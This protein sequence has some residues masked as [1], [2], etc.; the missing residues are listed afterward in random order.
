MNGPDLQGI[1]GRNLRN[2]RRQQRLT[3]GDLA[4]RA[5]I[6]TG[7]I[8]DIETSKRWP[9][10]DT[11]C[12]L[13]GALGIA[14]FQLLLPTEDSPWFDRRRVLSSYNRRLIE[15]IDRSCSQ[16]FEEMIR[17]FGKGDISRS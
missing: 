6:S 1:V 11:V 3:Q 8:S 5:G 9:S 16:V 12:R 17:C 14:P 4:R 15:A 7:F 2:L 10:A 13:T